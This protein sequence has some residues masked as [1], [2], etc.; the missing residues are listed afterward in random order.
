MTVKTDITLSETPEI[1]NDLQIELKT[2][3]ANKENTLTA[4]KAKLANKNRQE[5]LAIKEEDMPIRLVEKK[6]KSIKFGVVGSGQAGS[7][8]AETFYDAGYAAIVF[9]TASQDLEHIKVP[10]SNK[11]LLQYGLGGAAKDLDIGRAAAE[12]HKEAINELV[13]THLED[14]QILL[15]CLSLGGGSGAGSC[16]TIIDVLS[17]TGKPVVVVTVL[18]MSAEDAQI[19]R[20]ALET[21][22]KLAKEAQNK[23]I[24]NL[25]VVDNAKIETIYSD[26]SPS[27]F[28]SVSNKAIVDPIDTFNTLSSLSSAMKPLDPMEWAKV[29]TDGGGLSVYGNL[30]VTNFSD[31]TAIAEAVIENLNSGLLASGF[32]LKQSRY[33]GV[34]MVA[35]KNTWDQV[36]NIAITYAQEMIGDVC[37][38]P[39]GIF[40]GLYESEEVEPNLVKVYSFFSGLGLPEVRVQQLKK[41][42]AAFAERAKN[43]DTERNLSLKLD[44]NRDEVT[45]AAEKIR[46]QISSKKSAFGGLLNNTVQ[47]KRRR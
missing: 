32:D 47:D 17:A 8:L 39:N 40:H 13:S 14:C 6:N 46:A 1:V 34:M 9:N 19:K 28:F 23:R 38:T 35:N 43:K 11:Y 2:D 33:V 3:L 26:V 42:A 15:F 7:R 41:D 31:P 22:S 45:S 18:P 5:E 12:M 10:N 37:G 24:H 21:L 4:L 44:T 30:N 27:A 29:M 16:E 20:N 36:P 25:I